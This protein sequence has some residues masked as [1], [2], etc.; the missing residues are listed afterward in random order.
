MP[1]S[2]ESLRCFIYG[3]RMELGLNISASGARSTFRGLSQ[4]AAYPFIRRIGYLTLFLLPVFF[5]VLTGCAALT[6]RKPLEAEVP[7]KEW[8]V[9]RYSRFLEQNMA[10]INDLY[11]AVYRP[12]PFV[13]DTAQGSVL[14]QKLI[15]PRAVMPIVAALEDGE[16][17][18]D[19]LIWSLYEYVIREYRFVVDARYWP[20]IDE[21]LE[22]KEADCKGLSLLL[23]SLFLAA[24]YDAYAAISNG[25][26]WVRGSDGL[27]W[28]TFE[29]DKN[30][31]RNQVY[32]ING[33]YDNPLFKVYRDQAFKRKRK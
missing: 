27:R 21:T 15:N 31:T 28:H 33:F 10:M 17:P 11:S 24:G 3:I 6:G 1:P 26:M 9:K 22:R 16:G 18:D 19:A 32:S 23:M 13:V 12:Y 29:L 20:T 8:E 30:P 2:L 7:A 5:A 14:I 4:T 25:H